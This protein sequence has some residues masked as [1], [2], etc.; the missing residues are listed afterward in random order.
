MKNSMDGI[1]QRILRLRGLRTG[2][3]RIGHDLPAHRPDAVAETLLRLLENRNWELLI[4]LAVD[5]G[6]YL[7][8]AVLE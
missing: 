3:P 8:R 7:C 6:E 4:R 5:L 1:F 2:A